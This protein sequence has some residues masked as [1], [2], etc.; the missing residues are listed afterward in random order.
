[1]SS[2]YASAAVTLHPIRL[3]LLITDLEMGGAERCLVQLATRL[4]GT[5][6]E[7]VVYSLAARPPDLRR[8]LVPVLES[9]GIQVHHLDGRGLR[10]APGVAWRLARLLRAQQ[11]QVLL[12][13]LFH[14]N[15]LGRV[16]ARLAAVPRVVCGIR[17]AEPRRSHLL[18]DRWTTRL[19]NVHVCVSQAVADFSRTRG[20]L[21]AEKLLVIPNGIDPAEYDAVAPA[22]LELL[23]VP[24]GHRVL[25]YV[26]RLDPQKGLAGFLGRAAAWLGRL[27]HHDLLVVGSGPQRDELERLARSCGIA[28][29]V[30]FVGWRNDVPAILRASRL[31]VLPSQWEGMPNVVL[32]A[33]AC[34]LPVAASDVAGVRELLGPAADAQTA[35]AENPELLWE[36]ILTTTS[37]DELA[38]RLGAENRGRVEAHFNM[39]SMVTQ[40]DWLISR[41]AEGLVS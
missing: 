32:E 20:G 17:V 1:M 41:L 13:F 26:G 39:A 25:T 30:H 37:Q 22:D 15:L 8:S 31:L 40:Y 38:D 5:R 18:W 4:D 35:P 29:R 11:P 34:R 33:M 27:P 2:S 14:A 10:D 24:P 9:R 12:T 28:E 3:A 36:N 19:V 16:A 23:G 6:F 7:A 21:P